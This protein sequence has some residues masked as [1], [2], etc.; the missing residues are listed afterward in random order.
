MGSIPAPAGKT[1]LWTSTRP[2]TEV[3]PRA[4][5]ENIDDLPASVDDEG[6]SPRLRGKPALMSFEVDGSGPSPRLRGKPRGHHRRG[7]P[8]RSIPAP[9]GKTGTAPQRVG[10]CGV[11][12]RACGEN[13]DAD[14]GPVLRHGPSPR[15]RGKPVPLPAVLHPVGSIPAPA[16]KTWGGRS[17]PASSTVHPRACGENGGSRC[18]STSGQG[19]SPR[20]RGKPSMTPHGETSR[21]SIPAPAGKTL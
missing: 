10:A 3:H 16:G 9:A 20:L 15:L 17:P 11:H 13:P 1:L 2:G 18:L 4:C 7:L 5:G 6:P 12:P 8:R 21:R 14:L 19:P